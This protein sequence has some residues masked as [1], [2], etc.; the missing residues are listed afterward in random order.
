MN[1]G[2][3]FIEGIQLL[4]NNRFSQVNNAGHL[5]TGF[6]LERGV[7]QGDPISAYL[8]IIALEFLLHKLRN[9][10]S[11][12]KITLSNHEEILAQAYADDLTIIIPRDANTLTAIMDIIKSFERVSG[13]AINVSKTVCINIGKNRNT[14]SFCPTFPI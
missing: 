5:S 3:Q 14:T 8:F 7:P 11:L 13:L 10:P 6:T 2:D 4:L 9:H 12:K 1:F